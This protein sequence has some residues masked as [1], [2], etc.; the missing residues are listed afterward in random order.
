MAE[1]KKKTEELVEETPKTEEGTPATPV[2][3]QIIIEHDGNNVH[4]KKAEVSGKIELI[5]ILQMVI[6]FLNQPKP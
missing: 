4:V 6:T 5:G 2:M 3:R 1:E